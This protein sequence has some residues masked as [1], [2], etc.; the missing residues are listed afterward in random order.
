MS[1]RSEP[2]VLTPW[3]TVKQVAE[4]AQ[5]GDGLVYREIRAGRLRAA[6][7]GGRRDLRIHDDWIDQWL[8][9]SAEPVEVRPRLAPPLLKVR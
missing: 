3:R 7:I 5:C 2:L 8:T 1:P 4:R 6:R 9:A